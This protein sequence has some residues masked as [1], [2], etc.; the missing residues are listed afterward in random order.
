V[1]EALKGTLTGVGAVTVLAVT[2]SACDS[3]TSSYIAGGAFTDLTA[4][5]GEFANSASWLNLAWRAVPMMRLSRRPTEAATRGAAL[6]AWDLVD[7][8]TD[9]VPA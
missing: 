4:A 6:L 1:E 7:G 9:G 3:Q 5:K 8:V 2:L